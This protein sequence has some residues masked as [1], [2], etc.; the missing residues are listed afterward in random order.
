M[1]L[2]VG[3]GNPGPEYSQTRHN[4]GFM[5][6]DRLA[7][8]LKAEVNKNK[9][10]ALIGEAQ[11]GCEKILLV[12]PQTYMNLSG[13]AVGMLARWYK[14]SAEDIVVI[15]DDMD[16]P[17]GKLRIRPQGGSGGHNGMKSIIA[18]LGTEKFA[19]IRIGIGRSEDSIK[20]V[21]G[22]FSTEEMKQIDS[23]ISDAVKAVHVLVCRDVNTAMNKYNR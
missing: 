4:V 7:E 21:L 20:H 1:K 3:L 9:F 18:H 16:L 19:R 13:E 5:T 23:V 6:V 8:E 17:L 12:K 15:Y 2:I 22:N 11:I 14:L 10:K